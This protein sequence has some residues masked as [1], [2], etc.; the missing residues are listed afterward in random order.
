METFFI[1]CVPCSG[2][3]SYSAWCCSLL[4]HLLLLL[5]LAPFLSLPVTLLLAQLHIRYS[6]FCESYGRRRCAPRWAPNE[7]HFTDAALAR[8]FI[9]CQT[10]FAS[11]APVA[12]VFPSPLAS[13]ASPPSYS[14]HGKSRKLMK[15]ICQLHFAFLPVFLVFASA[16][17]PAPPAGVIKLPAAF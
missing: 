14:C 17:A 12:K 16:S 4:F 10:E 6:F 15:L 5:C 8:N 9:R 3:D 11:I 7:F 2:R 13:L 1:A